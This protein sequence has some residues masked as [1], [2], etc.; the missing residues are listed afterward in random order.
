MNKAEASEGTRYDF[1]SLVELRL[2]LDEFQRD[3]SEIICFTVRTAQVCWCQ[4]LI[5]TEKKIS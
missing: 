4:L 5:C 1:F 3:L 2:D